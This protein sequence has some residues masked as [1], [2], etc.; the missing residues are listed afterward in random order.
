MSPKVDD[1]FCTE[2]CNNNKILVISLDYPKA[3]SH[4]YPAG[5]HAIADIVMAILEDDSLPF[6]KNRVAIGG[7]SAG[8]NLSLAATQDKRLQGKVGG[9]VAYY[10]PTNWITDIDWKLSTRPTDAG[11]DP[12]SSNAPMFDYAYYN[13]DQDLRDPKA[14]VALASRE[15][16]PPKICIIGCELDML[17]RDSEIMAEQLASVG[18]GPKTGTDT[19]WEQNGIR[20]EKVLNE[21]HGI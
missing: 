5:V 21:E 4:P 7:F 16:L 10:P 12:L 2:F 13:A 18:D 1:K 3:P 14:S 11:P 8:A 6:D 20:W 15:D 19:V 17:C 9:V